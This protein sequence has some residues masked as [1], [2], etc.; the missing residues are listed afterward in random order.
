MDLTPF[1]YSSVVGQLDYFHF[2][3]IV[4]NAAMNIYV[5]VFV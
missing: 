1:I 5:L 3:A 2:L 4:R